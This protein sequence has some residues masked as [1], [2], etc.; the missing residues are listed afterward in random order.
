MINCKGETMNK[1][2]LVDALASASGL[3]KTVANK[4]LNTFMKTIT[5]VL[6][7]GGSVV[8]PG[9][10]S[11]KTGNRSERLGRNPRTGQTMKI[12]ASRVPK[13]IAGKGLKDS[14]RD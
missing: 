10:G 12:P 8:L 5:E 1:S 2:E 3:T 4:V 7:E 13:F 9:F 6:Q 11:F 14:V